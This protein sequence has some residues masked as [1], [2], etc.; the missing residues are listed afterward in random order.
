MPV[1]F[2]AWAE[3]IRRLDESLGRLV[4]TA[5]ELGL[6]PPAGREWFE[7]LRHKLLPQV[8]AEPWLVVA[9]VGG[10]NIGKSVVFNHL[11]GQAASGVSPMAAKT[12]HPVCLVPP[13][14][15]DEAA[16]RRIFA[17]FALQPWQSEQDPWTECDEHRLYWK[18]GEHVPPR[19]LVLDTP[20]IDSD[21]PVNWQRA[22]IVR[23]TADVLVAVL[24][25]QKYNDA[26]VKQFF[27]HAAQADKPIIV[28]FNQC[29]LND[30]RE[31]WPEW[32]RTF[33]TETGVDVQ[34]TYVVPYDRGAAGK[35]SLPFHQVGRDGRA[36]P[37][38]GASLRDELATL[39]FD[40]IKIRTLRGALAQVIDREHG[41]PSYLAD[42]QQVGQGFATAAKTLGDKQIAR[43][44]WPAFPPQPLVDEMHRW[45]D[46][47]RASWSRRVHGTYRV[48]GNGMLWPIR[49]AI[50]YVRGEP[51]DPLV[52]FKQL[53]RQAIISTVESMFDELTRLADVGNEILKPRLQPYVGGEARSRF[54]TQVVTAH[55]QL[56]AIDE[57]FRQY[58]H[59]RLDRFVKES[60]GY[61]N[62]LNGIDPAAAVLR[63]VITFT[64]SLGLP[65]EHVLHQAATQVVTDTVTQTAISQVAFHT[66]ATVAIDAAA[67]AGA[68]GGMKVLVGLFQDM[69]LGF[70][71]QRRHWFEQLIDDHL[72]GKL[73]RELSSGAA[74]SRSTDFV[75][76][77]SAVG[78]LMELLGD[79]RS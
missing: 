9:V 78:R 39:H 57:Q 71:A 65:I 48:L 11:V 37:S 38:M 33:V 22:D 56:P 67:T 55:E 18:I 34:L 54:L 61:H 62:W 3:Q 20:D 17:G 26:T 45:W 73:R 60:P 75:G 6:A 58:I 25:Q 19:L 43:A 70:C 5:T 52:L 72:L 31:Y 14:F 40:A 30:D 27:R 32:L 13:G 10:T 23:Q 69:Q 47:R 68:S 16:L 64:F 8:S 44:N 12:K 74:V 53:E 63:P 41:V 66:G 15:A 77:T 79:K 29:D 1:D 46:A 24:T 7:L 2:L 21:A 49:K 50:H 36:E 4:A 51:I 76:V 35:L 28:V 42:V 59:D